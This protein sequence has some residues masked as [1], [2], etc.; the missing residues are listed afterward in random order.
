MCRYIIDP[1]N[2]GALLPPKG[3]GANRHQPKYKISSHVQASLKQ[4]A[5]CRS[6]RLFGSAGP[7][8][9]LKGLNSKLEASSKQ[10]GMAGHSMFQAV[11]I[12]APNSSVASVSCA[13]PSPGSLV[14]GAAAAKLASASGGT[15]PSSKSKTGGKSKAVDK[16]MCTYCGQMFG[17][18]GIGN[19]EAKCAEKGRQQDLGAAQVRA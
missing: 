10:S 13:L 11:Y 12:L 3:P 1:Q 8:Q 16:V 18:Q 5:Q 17:K 7:W 9:L 6:E 15:L 4:F 19:H 14:M 2:E